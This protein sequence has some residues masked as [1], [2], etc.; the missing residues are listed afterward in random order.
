VATDQPIAEACR[1]AR[2]KRDQ[3]IQAERERVHRMLGE[4]N[5]ELRAVMRWWDRRLGRGR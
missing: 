2:A 4:R 5:Q 1:R 3:E